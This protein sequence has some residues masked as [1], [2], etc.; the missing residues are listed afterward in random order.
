MQN[1]I[2]PSIF[3]WTHMWNL[4]FPVLHVALLALIYW[5]FFQ[6]RLIY[7][8]V[9]CVFYFSSMLLPFVIFAVLLV[10]TLL[11]VL[12]FLYPVSNAKQMR[13]ANEETGQKRS[14]SN[15]T[16]SDSESES[17]LILIY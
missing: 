12:Y 13:L 8:I 14:E 15:L 17:I 6:F 2:K 16:K 11:I 7:V 1:Y 10:V 9:I 5:I 3:V 4:K